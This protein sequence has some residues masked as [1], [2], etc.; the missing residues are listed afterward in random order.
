M[1]RKNRINS[2]PALIPYLALIA[3]TILTLLPGREQTASAFL[4]TVTT[5]E[6]NTVRT[7]YV[8]EEGRIT[9]AVD[10]QYATLIR[11]FDDEGKLILE[12]YF[13]ENGDPAVTWNLTSAVSYEYNDKGQAERLHYLDGSGNPVVNIYGYD[14]I[15]RT[16]NEDGLALTDTYYI[17]NEQVECSEGYYGCERAAYDDKSRATEYRYL[18]RDGKLTIQ[19]N[20]YSVVKRDYS[21]DGWNVEGEYYY[22]DHDRPVAAIGGQ[23]GYSREFDDKWREILMTFLDADGNALDTDAGYASVRTVY[24]DGSIKKFF[25]DRNGDPATDVNNSY[26]TETVNGENYLLNADGSRMFRIDNFLYNNTLIVMAAGIILTVIAIFMRGKQRIILIAACLIIIV[27]L[28]ILF[29]KAGATTTHVAFFGAFRKMFSNQS[30]A[31]DVINNIWL[32]VPFGAALYKRGS[33][34][35]L[36]PIIVSVIIEAAQ[37]LTGAGVCEAADVVCNSLGGLIGYS[38][39]SAV[40]VRNEECSPQL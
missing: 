30:A 26:G 6:G 7:D 25:L 8:D 5:E 15:H 9:Y 38:C 33:K 23:Y 2:I 36:I 14:T 29:R 17:G 39:L 37:F 13:D 16:Y 11:T 35:W 10:S 3:V 21:E 32:F 4:T 28:T 12:E 20:G 27:L 40:S 1:S 18:D 22:D 19:K 24:E 34:R 31:R